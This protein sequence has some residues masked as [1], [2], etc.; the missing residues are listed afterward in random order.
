MSTA[1]QQAADFMTPFILDHTEIPLTAPLAGKLPDTLRNKFLLRSNRDTNKVLILSSDL[2]V[3]KIYQSLK[4]DFGRIAEV[5]ALKN[6]KG[7]PI[8]QSTLNAMLGADFSEHHILY[9]LLDLIYSGD[10][11]YIRKPGKDTAK[12]FS[13]KDGGSEP[14]YYMRNG[15]KL[16]LFENKDVLFPVDVKFSK[17]LLKIKQSI[18][19]KIARFGKYPDLHKKGKKGKFKIKVEKEGLGQIYYNIYRLGYKPELYRAFD[20]DIDSVDTIYPVLITYDNAYSSLG[21]NAYANKKVTSIRRRLKKMFIE[22]YGKELDLKRYTLNKP[23]II[24]ID[25]LIMYSLKLRKQE[26]NLFD[27][28]DEYNSLVD[29]YDH[30]LSSFSS[31]MTDHHKL[32]AQGDEFIKLLYSEV[33]EPNEAP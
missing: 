26:L 19:Y 23:I 14:D 8:K 30:N 33:L 9:S 21:V 15:N 10:S 25:T 6:E 16:I 28:L 5:K 2:L 4:F 11:N 1:P 31:F 13:E 29:K 12:Y 3:D 7:K 24:D 32:V 17:Q 18:T 22:K 20:A 27:L